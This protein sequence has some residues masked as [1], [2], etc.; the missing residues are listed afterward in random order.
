MSTDMH[1]GCTGNRKC[2][3]TLTATRN[4]KNE[5]SGKENQRWMIAHNVA[6][7]FTEAAEL[8]RK[9]HRSHHMSTSASVKFIFE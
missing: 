5:V 8:G 2:H 3:C 6:C 4:M 7:K 1:G 9:L